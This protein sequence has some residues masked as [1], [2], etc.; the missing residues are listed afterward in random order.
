MEL[1]LLEAFVAVFLVLHLLRPLLKVLWSLDGLVLL[2]LLALGIIIGLFPSYGFR[3]ECIP[4]LVFSIIINLVNLPAFFALFFRLHNDDYRD[5]GPVYIVLSLA[6][7]V[8]VLWIA[9]HFAPPVDMDLK[10]E[11]VDSLVLHDRERNTE[12]WARIYAREGTGN[13]VPRARPLLLLL[14]PVAGSVPAIDGV[15]AELSERGFTVLTYSRPG[16][17]SPAVDSSGVYTRLFPPALYR[18][19]SAITRGLSDAQANVYGKD[20]EKERKG[21]AEFLLQELTRNVSL[22]S[23]LLNADMNSVFLAGYGSGGAALTVLSA[24][25]GFT[26]RYEWVKGIIAIESPILSSL[27]GEA[28]AAPPVP[29]TNPLVTGFRV[30]RAFADS[31]VPRKITNIGTVPRP[32]LPVLFIVSDRVIQARTGRYETILRTMAVSRDAALLAAVP[33]AGPCDYSDSPRLYP[34]Y[35]ILF[36]GAGEALA[37][38]EDYPGLTASLAANFAALVLE[39]GTP[40]EDPAEADEVSDAAE[41]LPSPSPLIKT[42]LDDRIH[43]ESGGVWQLPDSRAILHP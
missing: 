9:L 8:F 42:R 41:A 23:K 19:I 11:G 43:L 3:P 22:R 25:S 10:K 29:G 26:G 27:E 37:K 30:V 20:L 32:G 39:A 15:C 36:R 40:G 1:L 2:P 33:G 38:A 21:D 24:S 35:S 18:L 4:L 31:L 16:F 5:R 7:F 13:S 14:P 34:V 6:V 12:L 28:L 17:D